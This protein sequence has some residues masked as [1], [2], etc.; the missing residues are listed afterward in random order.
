ML[1]HVVAHVPYRQ[2]TD[3]KVLLHIQGPVLR[4]GR[5]QVL[6]YMKGRR[7]SAIEYQ[8]IDRVLKGRTTVTRSQNNSKQPLEHI[9]GLRR[10][11]VRMR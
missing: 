6:F 2:H 1:C 11:R 7:H 10:E 9:D 5:F 3:P 8:W 4:H